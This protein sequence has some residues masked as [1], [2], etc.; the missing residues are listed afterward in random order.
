E[1]EAGIAVTWRRLYLPGRRWVFWRPRVISAGI[2]CRRG[3]AC[4]T[5]LAAL[6]LALR[7]AGLSRQS[8]SNLA[9]IDFKGQEPGLRGAAS[10]LGLP[11]LTF[12][13]AELAAC[14]ERHPH[15]QRSPRV[16]SF[17]GIP[18]V[19]EP[20]AMLAAGEGE[21]LWPKR[22]YQGVTVALALAL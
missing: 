4:A 13:P 8:L 14:L 6:G 22:S 12:T 11:L 17:I 16:A 10:R 9:S 2:G 21:L 5:I 3:V 18:G 19:C 15:L 7:E 1:G 20:A